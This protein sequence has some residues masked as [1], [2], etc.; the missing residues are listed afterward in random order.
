MKTNGGLL[1]AGACAGTAAPRDYSDRLD[2]RLPPFLR[3]AWATAAARGRWAGPLNR[4]V[5]EVRRAEWLSVAAGLRS[6]A[7]MVVPKAEASALASEWSA[8]DLISRLLGQDDAAQIRAL[9]GKTPYDSSLHDVHLVTRRERMQHL[10]AIWH[11]ADLVEIACWLGYPACCAAFLRT[12][13]LQQRALDTT[14]A[15]VEGNTYAENGVQ[16]ADLFD[17]AVNPL[18]TALGL[19]AIP[20]RPCSFCCQETQRLA[21]DYRQL[22][23]HAD[24]P[25]VQDTLEA[26]LNW[27]VEWS[28]LH[29]IVEVRLPILKLCYDGDATATA[30]KVRLTGGALP[31]HAAQGL[32]FLYQPPRRLRAKT[33]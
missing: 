28:T 1:P 5:D 16:V 24:S 18:L 15:M 11:R 22:T 9:T 14:W 27:P 13:T 4:L 29:G 30:Y 10:E 23:A 21:S 32:E 2:F 31:E 7:L 12:A 3:M 17:A 33:G 19:R 25:P 26:V 6:A 20:H 8:S